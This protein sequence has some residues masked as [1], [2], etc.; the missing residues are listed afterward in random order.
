MLAA[1]GIEGD[2]YQ[3]GRSKVFLRAGT[4]AVLDQLRLRKVMTPTA[5]M[6]LRMPE[7][8]IRKDLI[9]VI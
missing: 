1:T 9:T 7:G 4:M 8:L 2:Q 3:L 5:V 6:R